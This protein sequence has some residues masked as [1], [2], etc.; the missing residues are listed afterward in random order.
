MT[1]LLKFIDDSPALTII[2]VILI[3][4]F[5]TDWIRAARGDD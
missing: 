2:L 1:A 5:V 4:C 3:G